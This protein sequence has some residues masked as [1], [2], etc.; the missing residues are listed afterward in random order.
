MSVAEIIVLLLVA[1]LIGLGLYLR[2]RDREVAEVN[3]FIKNHQQEHHSDPTWRDVRKRFPQ[4]KLL[5][6]GPDVAEKLARKDPDS[7]IAF[8][9]PRT[10]QAQRRPLCRAEQN[11]LASMVRNETTYD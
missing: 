2:L 6:E 7:L 1:G 11:M 8:F 10:C 3:R 9:N 5:H 4:L